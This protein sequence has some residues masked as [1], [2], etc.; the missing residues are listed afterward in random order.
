M[1][2]LLRWRRHSTGQDLLAHRSIDLCAFSI[3]QTMS[4]HNSIIDQSKSSSIENDRYK[5]VS[6]FQTT[7][8]FLTKLLRQKF[9]KKY[10]SIHIEKI[11]GTL[12]LWKGLPGQI[13]FD[14]WTFSLITWLP[15]SINLIHTMTTHSLSS[16]SCHVFV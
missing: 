6:I 11:D 1:D 5:I 7:D 2:Q 4:L 10:L 16:D 15:V 12:A 3:H 14:F 8:E 13:L 9:C